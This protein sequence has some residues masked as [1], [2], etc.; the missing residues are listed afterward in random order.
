MSAHNQTWM[1]G[2]AASSSCRKKTLFHD[3]PL[4]RRNAKRL[5]RKLA[6]KK[7]GKP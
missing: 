7:G 2:M 5:A 3:L 4:T 1:I 6:K